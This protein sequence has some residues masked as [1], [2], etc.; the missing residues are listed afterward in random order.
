MIER[1][2]NM[3]N[4]SDAKVNDKVIVKLSFARNLYEG[5]ITKI[6]SRYVYVSYTMNDN[7]REEVFL[8]SSGNEKC[9]YTGFNCDKILPYDKDYIETHNKNMADSLRKNELIGKIDDFNFNTL[10]LEQ[11]EEIMKIIENNI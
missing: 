4:F 1:K 3:T 2:M 9:A 7:S 10:S 6:N 8:T 11:L 5:T